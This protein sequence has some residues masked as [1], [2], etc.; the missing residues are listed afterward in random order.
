MVRSGSVPHSVPAGSEIRRFGPVR[1]VRFGSVYYSIL[2]LFANQPVKF[3][4]W[5]ANSP[6]AWHHQ[7]NTGSSSH[8]IRTSTSQVSHLIRKFTQTPLLLNPLLITFRCLWTKALLRKRRPLGV[9]AW[10]VPNQGV[11]GSF[12]CC[13]SDHLS[14]SRGQNNKMYAYIYIYIYVYTHM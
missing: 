7:S 13:F 2:M 6:H 5:F 4:M 10:K 1:P 11:E 8:V 3:R 9:L 12:S 14:I